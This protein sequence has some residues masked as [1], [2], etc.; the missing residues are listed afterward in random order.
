MRWLLLLVAALVLGGGVGWWMDHEA[1]GS[2]P[3]D[4]RHQRGSAK[5]AG[6]ILYRW[7]DAAGVVNITDTVPK[8]RRYTV[9]RIDPNRN[10]VPMAHPV[11]P[12]SIPVAAPRVR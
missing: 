1:G 3:H 4:G 9:V 2:A 7:I 11:D 6:P 8:G 10:V 12:A 5:D